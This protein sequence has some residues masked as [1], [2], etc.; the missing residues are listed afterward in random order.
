[1]RSQ[2]NRGRFI[3]Y[4][5]LLLLA[6]SML[7]P[8]YWMAITSLKR[9]ADV[10]STEPKLLPGKATGRA[11]GGRSPLVLPFRNHQLQPVA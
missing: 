6:A 8:F 1:M 10:F 2:I 3:V 9:K 5:L 11:G 7:F 4:I